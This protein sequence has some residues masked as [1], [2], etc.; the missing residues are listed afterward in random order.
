MTIFNVMVK[1]VFHGK[2]FGAILTLQ[3]HFSVHKSFVIFDEVFGKS[4][5][6][7]FYKQQILLNIYVKP[8]VGQFFMSHNFTIRVFLENGTPMVLSY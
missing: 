2:P 7:G 6:T 8:H 1:I 3:M 4:L 5:V